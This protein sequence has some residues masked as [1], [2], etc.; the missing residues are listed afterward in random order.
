MKNVHN[1]FVY[2][3]LR[4]PHM[5]QKVINRAVVAQPDSL[6]GFS[7]QHLQVNSATYYVA[8]PDPTGQIDGKL[9]TNLS[10]ADLALLD[11]YETAAYQRK[12]LK[13]ASGTWAWVYCRAPK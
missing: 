7:R 13:L 8:D 12:M 5:R 6:L 11:N 3:T 9:I 10:S 4:L 2:G 1:L